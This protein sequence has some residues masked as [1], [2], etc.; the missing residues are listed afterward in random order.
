MCTR[1]LQSLGKASFTSKQNIIHACIQNDF[2]RTANWRSDTKFSVCVFGRGG[3]TAD[4]V[5]KAR[6]T[7]TFYPKPS[8][9][10]PLRWD[11]EPCNTITN[12]R[13]HIQWQMHEHVC[14]CTHTYT[15]THMHTHTRA[16]ARDIK[17]AAERQTHSC[18]S[19]WSNLMIM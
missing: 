5:L 10:Q 19:K 18:W 17:I 1:G 8:L 15:D 3:G 12:T 11:R 2:L 13:T 9:S 4:V 6:S 14:T 7:E 16:R